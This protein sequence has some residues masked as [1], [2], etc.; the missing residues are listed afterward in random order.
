MWRGHF[1]TTTPTSTPTTSVVVSPVRVPFLPRIRYRRPSATPQISSGCI[2]VMN[3]RH[4]VRSDLPHSPY[5]QK[6]NLYDILSTKKGPLVT[7]VIKWC[8]PIVLENWGHMGHYLVWGQFYV[9]HKCN[10]I[11]MLYMYFNVFFHI[12]NL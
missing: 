12:N 2:L 8:V 5:A 4:N 3:T 9:F 11:C 7:S 1:D 6:L 10:F